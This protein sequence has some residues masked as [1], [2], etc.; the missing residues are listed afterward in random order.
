MYHL[1]HLINF[2]NRPR[3]ILM[4][5]PLFLGNI[6]VKMFFNEKASQMFKA[7]SN[8]LLISILMPPLRVKTTGLVFGGAFF[9]QSKFNVQFLD[10]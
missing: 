7:K 3:S 8:A 1:I 9:L 10:L 4:Y 6:I 5:C 2:I